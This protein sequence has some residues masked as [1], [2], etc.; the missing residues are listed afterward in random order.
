MKKH[1]FSYS[2]F[3]KAYQK[4]LLTQQLALISFTTL[5]MLFGSFY[6]AVTSNLELLHRSYGDQAMFQLKVGD[7]FGLERS[8]RVASSNGL[9]RGLSITDLKG[10]NLYEFNLES[11]PPGVLSNIGFI[12]RC[13]DKNE[14]PYSDWKICY[15]INFIKADIV[16]PLIYVVVILFLIFFIERRHSHSFSTQVETQIKELTTLAG[17]VLLGKTQSSFE[18]VELILEFRNLL[19]QL[20]LE[21]NRAK[22]MSELALIGKIASQVAHDIRSPLAALDVAISSTDSMPEDKRVMVRAAITRIRDIANDLTAKSKG[23]LTVQANEQAAGGTAPAL[24]PEL[25]SSLLD[26]II[27]EKRLQFR[28]NLGVSIS[29]DPCAGAY[30]HFAEIDGPALSRA[31]SNL[32]NNAVEALPERGGLIEVSL[33]RNP[34]KSGQVLITISDTGRGIPSALLKKLGVRGTTLGKEGTEGAGSGLGI[35]HAKTAIESFGG[36]IRFESIEGKG[37]TVKITLPSCKPPEWFFSELKIKSE[38]KVVIVDDD[39]TIHQIWDGRLKSALRNFAPARVH[40]FSN[41]QDFAKWIQA[42]IAD[43]SACTDYV[44]LI[45]YEFISHKLTGLDLIKL[46]EIQNH[47]ILVTSRF[48]EPSVRARAH[49]MGVRLIPKSMAGLVPIIET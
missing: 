32:I 29:F 31:I 19:H 36:N 6:W 27:S 33:K 40:H 38:Q 26:S 17:G 20:T 12:T 25:L 35:Y 11:T 46:S 24:K 47:A 39:Q 43:P 30:G 2:A 44:Y 42:E 23:A 21:F 22:S 48:D 1:P 41:P 4:R 13:F 5:M 15:K 9:L 28:S 45:D 7:T 3:F 49:E 18:N 10:Q 14:A 16:F 8:S 34:E 37:T